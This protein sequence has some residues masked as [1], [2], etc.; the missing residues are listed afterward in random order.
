[1]FLQISL[2][3]A[4]VSSRLLSFNYLMHAPGTSRFASGS[5][6]VQCSMVNIQLV[7]LL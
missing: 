3:S 7:G 2:L 5:I 6:G 4:F 1:M